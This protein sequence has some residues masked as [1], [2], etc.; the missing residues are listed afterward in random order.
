MELSDYLSASKRRWWILVLIPLVAV[1]AVAGLQLQ[2]PPTFTATATVAAP[3]LVGGASSNQYSGSA[4]PKTFVANFQAV[5]TSPVIVQKVSSDF[6]IPR[7][8]ISSGLTSSEDGLS[9]V[10]QVTYTGSKKSIVGPVAADAARQSI[11]FLFQTQVQVAKLPVTQAQQQLTSINNQLTA[12]AQA[13]G[14]PVPDRDYQVLATEIASLEETQAQASANNNAIE[15]NNLAPEIAA[16]KTQLTQLAGVLSTY[17]NLKDQQAQD[18]A[19]LNSANQ[20]YQQAQSQFDAAN[21]NQVVT[22]GATKKV[23]FLAA[24]APAAGVAVGSALAFAIAIVF[25]LEAVRR[26]RRPEDIDA[27]VDVPMEVRVI[28]V[29]AEAVPEYRVSEPAFVPEAPSDPGNPV[30]SPDPRATQ[31]VTAGATNGGPTNGN[32]HSNGSGNG[33]GSGNGTGADDPA[34][35]APNGA[36][37]SANEPEL[38]S[39][40]PAGDAGR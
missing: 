32:G 1:V 7:S 28:A 33:S 2:K 40:A 34:H 9:S 31:P 36:P 30:A 39:V 38:G 35:A 16:K 4:G 25:L 29:E 19:D 15:A 13:S 17:L 21:P 14:T 12:F 37:F 24:T 5:L 27:P 10:M 18:E 23:S 22:L 26:R 20:T 3:A 6:K 8:K 11:L